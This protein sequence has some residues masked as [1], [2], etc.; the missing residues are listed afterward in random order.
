MRE[1]FIRIGAV[2]RLGQPPHVLVHHA[3]RDGQR[4]QRVTRSDRAN[5]E[6]ELLGRDVLE[7]ASVL[8]ALHYE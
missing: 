4:E 7:R 8:N 6:H 5:P 2:R 3:L 1:S